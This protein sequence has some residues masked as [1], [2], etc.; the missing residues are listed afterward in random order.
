MAISRRPRADPP[1][2]LLDLPLSGSEAGTPAAVTAASET[3]DGSIAAGETATGETASSA[4]DAGGTRRPIVRRRP[5]NVDAIGSLQRRR[6]GRR[7]M[8]WLWLIL[9]LVVPLG[10]LVGY[11][12]KAEPPIAALSTDLLDFGDVRLAATGDEQTIR[13]SNQGEQVLRLDGAVLAGEAAGEFRI[14][15]DGCAGLEV[16][17]LAEC[18][19]RLTFTPAGRGAR[20]AQLRLDGNVPGGVQTVPLIGVGVA[21]ELSVEPSEIDFGQLGVGAAGAPAAVRLGNR[22]T[23]PLQLGRVELEGPAAGDF[24]RVADGCSSRRLPPG[25]R[26]TLR[27]AFAPEAAGERR[28]ELRIESD[29]GAPAMVTLAGRAALQVPRLRLEPAALDFEPR[30]LGTTGPAHSVTLAND[31]NAAL[32]VRGARIEGDGAGAFEVTAA[33][34]LERPVP[35]GEDCELE[36]RFSPTAEGAA[37]AVLAIDSTAGPEPHRLPLSGAGIAAHLSVDPARASFGEVAV[38]ASSALRTVRIASSG[39][40]ELR[41][42]AVTVGGADA[43]SFVAGGCA[44]AALAPGAECALEVRFRPQRAGPHRAEVVLRHNAGGGRIRLPLNGLGVTARLSL[45]SSRIDFGEV[46]VDTAARREL[47]LTNAGRSQLKVLRLRLTGVTTGFELEAGSCSGATLEPEASC[48]ARVVFRPAAAG[49][50]GLQLVID[51]TAGEPRQVQVTATAMAPPEPR[52]RLEPVSLAFPD[53][54]LGERSPIK[55]LTVHNPGTGRL[56]LEE[57]RL[58]G[59]HAGDFQLVPGSCAGAAFVAPQASCSFGI[60]FVPAAAGM[61]QARLTIG[62]NAAGGPAELELEGQGTIPAPLP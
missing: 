53:R 58:A 25:E 15:G 13:V 39:T 43:G 30:W 18:A 9:L 10:A 20:R 31:G 48:T 27:F 32:T 49:S 52:I 11:F 12:L 2:D 6:P 24:R 16:P 54:R 26:C 21:P 4:R 29:A 42:G 35:A 34:C 36:V 7:R 59:E 17:S 33:G 41:I 57:P 5:G 44:D 1:A 3:W 40:G 8:R 46:P 19:V 37:G 56:V 51:H 38:R 45:S 14:A 55:T 60:R 23:A 50:R 47:V 62:H 22:G 28:A 61:R